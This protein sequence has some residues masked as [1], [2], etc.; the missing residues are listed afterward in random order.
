M[1]SDRDGAVGY[2]WVYEV[3]AADAAAFRRAYGP[4]GAWV[5][6]FR[7]SHGYLGTDLLEEGGDPARFITIDYFDARRARERLVEERR[8]EYD[9]I[10]RRW[11]AV[12]GSERFLGE[13]VVS[14]RREP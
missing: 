8:D 7:R 3:A 13:F 5:A 1:G 12:T 14:A 10:D 2:V 6:F 4:D 9:A 11:E